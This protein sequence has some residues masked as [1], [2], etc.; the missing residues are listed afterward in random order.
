MKKHNEQF[1]I[2]L[3]SLYYYQKD[4]NLIVVSLFWAHVE[5]SN[6]NGLH[7]FYFAQLLKH[8]KTMFMFSMI[9]AGR[10]QFFPKLS[11]MY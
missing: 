10:K 6:T 5:Q 4:E 2:G 7:F 3:T 1:F 9:T 11:K 8:K